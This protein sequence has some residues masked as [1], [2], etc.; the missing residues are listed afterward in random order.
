MHPPSYF[1]PTY[2]APAYFAASAADYVPTVDLHLM[3]L[4]RGGGPPLALPD[5]GRARVVA[6]PGTIDWRRSRVLVP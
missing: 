2:F 5:R 4:L 3:V 1:A 6:L